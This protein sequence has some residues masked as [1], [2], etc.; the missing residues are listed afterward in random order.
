M[1]LINAD[2]SMS[3]NIDFQEIDACYKNI[4][5]LISSACPDDTIDPGLL[6]SDTASS[7]STS[8][9]QPFSYISS[10]NQF[11]SS[12]PQLKKIGR[13]EPQNVTSTMGDMNTFAYQQSPTHTQSCPATPGQ[14]PIQGSLSYSELSTPI[15]ALP[16]LDENIKMANMPSMNELGDPIQHTFADEQSNMNSMAKVSAAE[17]QFLLDEPMFNL[18]KS[19]QASANYSKFGLSN[20]HDYNN[21]KLVPR[22]NHP[23]GRLYP[24]NRRRPL[25]PRRSMSTNRARSSHGTRRDPE[26]ELGVWRSQPYP[27]LE[28]RPGSR[29]GAQSRQR[30]EA[31]TSVPE[32]VTKSLVTPPG[33]TE[34]PKRD[35]YAFTTH[36]L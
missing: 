17:L 33:K 25:L 12:I 20:S 1:D 21:N 9:V 34:D 19:H 13:A 16:L 5:G 30:R 26:R 10:E 14:E 24:T 35:G 7:P 23:P 4:S 8:E 3:G 18:C 6:M 28:S 15:T 27:P 31:P 36:C 11:F 22:T 2:M 32:Y 29:A